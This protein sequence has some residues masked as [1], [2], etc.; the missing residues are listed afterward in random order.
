MVSV[1]LA[2]N[3]RVIVQILLGLDFTLGRSEIVGI[4]F[5]D[6]FYICLLELFFFQLF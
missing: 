2:R 5:I 3:I 6:I 4:Y 1:E